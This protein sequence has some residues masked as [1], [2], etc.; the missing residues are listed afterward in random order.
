MRYLCAYRVLRN[1][2][3]TLVTEMLTTKTNDAIKGQIEL[4]LKISSSN[5]IPAEFINR[6]TQD[7][8]ILYINP[9]K[10]HSLSDLCDL[11]DDKFD[12]ILGEDLISDIYGNVKQEDIF[13]RQL[14]EL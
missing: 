1:D 6:D 3:P 10:L 2:E 4:M 8:G 13:E 7:L 14:P 12:D 9:K 5:N 11:D